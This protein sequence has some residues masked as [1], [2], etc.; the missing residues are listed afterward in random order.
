MGLSTDPHDKR[1]FQR[2]LKFNDD[3]SVAAVVDVAAGAAAPADDKG[4]VYLDVTYLPPV[5]L[6][7]IRVDPALLTAKKAVQ[8]DA[9][10]AQLALVTAEAT[11]AQADAQLRAAVDVAVKA[12]KLEIASEAVTRG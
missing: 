2:F 8:A 5:T 7:T 3:G 1:A 10:K 11:S 6:D 12:P 4:T 9:L